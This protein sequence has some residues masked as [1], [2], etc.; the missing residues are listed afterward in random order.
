[1][2][3]FT[4]VFQILCSVDINGSILQIWEQ[5]LEFSNKPGISGTVFE[6]QNCRF[7]PQTHLAIYFYT[8]SLVRQDSCSL[9]V[10]CFQR[11]H[12]NLASLVTLS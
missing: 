3:Y 10:K 11:T 1:M 12:L 5:S 9:V 7:S 2:H 8:V 6:P 4:Q